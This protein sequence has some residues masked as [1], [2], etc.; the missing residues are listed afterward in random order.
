M[1]LK[2]V[3]KQA[4]SVSLNTLKH[5]AQVMATQAVS[6]LCNM[7]LK[8][9]LKQWPYKQHQYGSTRLPVVT[10]QQNEIMH[11]NTDSSREKH[12]AQH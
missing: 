9:R 10:H 1:G 8:K 3:A 4:A 12:T 2:A 6:V 5:R 11:N 7:L